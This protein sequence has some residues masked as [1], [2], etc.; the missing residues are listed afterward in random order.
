MSPMT[1]RRCCVLSRVVAIR[2]MVCAHLSAPLACW[3]PKLRKKRWKNAS[4]R[5]APSS[6]LHQPALRRTLAESRAAPAFILLAC[7]P[8]IITRTAADRA[9]QRSDAAWRA[10]WHA[11]A[12]QTCRCTTAQGTNLHRNSANHSLWTRLLIDMDS[13]ELLIGP[14]AFP[15]PVRRKTLAPLAIDMSDD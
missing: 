5:T 9:L 13:G 3:A 14:R 2:V 1:S 12:S 10:L 15:P 11:T 4:N 8:T 7:V 6:L